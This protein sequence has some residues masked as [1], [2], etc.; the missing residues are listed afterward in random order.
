MTSPVPLIEV[1]LNG[2]SLTSTLTALNLLYQSFMRSAMDGLVN[3]FTILENEK[4]LV[5]QTARDANVSG[6]LSAS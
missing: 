6:I 3:V 2:D 5:Y 4:D 1:A